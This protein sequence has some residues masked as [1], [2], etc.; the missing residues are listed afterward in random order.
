MEDFE[1]WTLKFKIKKFELSNFWKEIKL[2]LITNKY[3]GIVFPIF[4][5]LIALSWVIH[6]RYELIK[7]MKLKGMLKPIHKCYFVFFLF[8]I[9][10]DGL[11]FL[12][13]IVLSHF[14]VI[15]WVFLVSF[16]IILILIIIVMKMI[17]ILLLLS[18][19][20]LGTANLKNA[21]HR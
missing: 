13:K 20:W 9:N 7:D 12:M 1:V 16:L 21:K 2:Q 3:F 8:L 19:F 18:D 14:V 17:L 11:L 5:L 6:H 15:K 4:C 10:I